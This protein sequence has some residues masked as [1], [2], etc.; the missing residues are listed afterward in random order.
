MIKEI[1]KKLA[2]GEPL[3]LSKLR[4][5]F[6]E[7]IP[8]ERLEFKEG[9]WLYTRINCLSSVDLGLGTC[10]C[11]SHDPVV[12]E[13]IKREEAMNLIRRYLEQQKRNE[14]ERTREITFFNKILELSQELSQDE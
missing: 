8:D 14:E 2:S 12:T 9:E 1:L 5:Q 11:V 7:D 6:G 3:I 4:N 10:H 13:K